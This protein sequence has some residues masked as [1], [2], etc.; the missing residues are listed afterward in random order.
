MK[1]H[2]FSILER[3]LELRTRNSGDRLAWFEHDGK[4]ITRTKRSHGNKDLPEHLIRQQL[5]LNEEQFSGLISCAF[6][7]G[8]YIDW[9]KSK[10]LIE[11]TSK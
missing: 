2:E 8:N 1:V 9:L 5:K 3:K 7:R 11:P 4:V 6:D 10:G